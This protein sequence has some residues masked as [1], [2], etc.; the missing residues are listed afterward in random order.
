MTYKGTIVCS[1]PNGV[2][3]PSRELSEMWAVLDGFAKCPYIAEVDKA[4]QMTD[5]KTKHKNMNG[6]Q[7]LNVP[8]AY[9]GVKVTNARNDGVTME[10]L[11]KRQSRWFLPVPLSRSQVI[12]QTPSISM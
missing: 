12:L 5:E 3:Q 6:A 7:Y 11:V 10:W 8:V 9:E 1:L 4:M 2:S